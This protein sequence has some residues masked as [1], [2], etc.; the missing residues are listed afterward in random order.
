[1][2]H[3]PSSDAVGRVLKIAPSRLDLTKTLG[4]MGL[5]SLMAIEL[6]NRLETTLGRPL[7]ATL[8]W[9]YPT[10]RGDRR[11]LA[12]EE[13]GVPPVAARTS[14]LP[15]ANWSRRWRNVASLTDEAAMLA[16]LGQ[17]AAGAR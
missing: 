15:K 9:N 16:L 13:H 12:G 5:N 14:R 3:D 11:L 4:N 8:A 17:P 10:D 1:M 2:L 7:S 6:R